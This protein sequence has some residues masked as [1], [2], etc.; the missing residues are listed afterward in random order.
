LPEKHFFSSGHIF[1]ANFLLADFQNISPSKYYS[2][3]S[4]NEIQIQSEF[5]K[6]WTCRFPLSQPRHN[7]FKMREQSTL[8]RVKKR[9]C[10]C[11]SLP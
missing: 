2:F 8:F 6:I 3:I 10:I 4:Y 9:H 11:H 1:Q 5:S 7:I